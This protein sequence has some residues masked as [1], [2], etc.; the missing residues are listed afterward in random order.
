MGIE[1]KM[2][3]NTG[4]LSMYCFIIVMTQKLTKLFLSL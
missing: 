4:S 2:F 1:N 3:K